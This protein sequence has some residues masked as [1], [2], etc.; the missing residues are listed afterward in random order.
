MS[1]AHVFNMHSNVNGGI[2]LSVSCL[3][4]GV[5]FVYWKSYL[6]VGN[7]KIVSACWKF[8]NRICFLKIP[9][10]SARMA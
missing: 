9:F 4:V 10:A 6:L 3:L 8:E 5:I 2:R 7:L 1:K